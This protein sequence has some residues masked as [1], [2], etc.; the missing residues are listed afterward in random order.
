M[1]LKAV[2][3]AAVFGLRPAHGPGLL[4]AALLAATA[5]ALSQS[6]LLID[7]GL[8]LTPVIA[9]YLCAALP[10]SIWP[11]LL[12]CVLASSSMALG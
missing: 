11:E 4:L 9:T 2:A 3:S 7:S 5:L 6:P 8:S 10:A 1:G 12:C